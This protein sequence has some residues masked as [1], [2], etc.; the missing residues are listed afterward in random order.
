MIYFNE[1]QNCLKQRVE[2]YEE[3]SPLE[4]TI[5][6]LYEYNYHFSKEKRSVKNKNG[7]FKKKL[8][9]ERN[10]A[11]FSIFNQ[12]INCLYN[13]KRRNSFF[14]RFNRIQFLFISSNC[15]RSITF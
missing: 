14:S 2:N 9:V 4:E 15:L 6:A 8:L 7:S 1:N 3:N 13:V 10:I 5:K 11:G 12:K